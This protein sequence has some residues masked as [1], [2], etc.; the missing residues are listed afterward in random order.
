M[1]TFET[2]E[3]ELTVSN[4]TYIDTYVKCVSS[5]F[6]CLVLQFDVIDNYTNM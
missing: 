6:H 4:D 3:M 5:V 2:L 1:Y